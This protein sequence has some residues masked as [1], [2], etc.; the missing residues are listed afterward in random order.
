MKNGDEIVIEYDDISKSYCIFWRPLIAVGM[1]D[2]EKEA[3][4]DLR[5][6]AHLGIDTE[7]NL[8]LTEIDKSR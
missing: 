2:T 6:A 1:G 3:L 8:K 4:E 7:V 5:Q